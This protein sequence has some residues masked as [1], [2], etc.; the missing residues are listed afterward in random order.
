MG[1]MD[2]VRKF[3][4]KKLYKDHMGQTNTGLDGQT[5]DRRLLSLRKM[6]RKQLE[7]REKEM[8][9]EQIRAEQQ[10]KNREAWRDNSYLK[11][12]CAPVRSKRK[13]GQDFFRKG[14]V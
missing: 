9:R 4:A 8:L 7:L 14:R 6:R 13:P 12:G 3:S 11:N 1:I 5:E 2:V 10:K